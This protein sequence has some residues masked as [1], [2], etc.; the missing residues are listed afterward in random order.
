VEQAIQKLSH[1][2]NQV[3]EETIYSLMERFI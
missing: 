1:N 2:G 3:D